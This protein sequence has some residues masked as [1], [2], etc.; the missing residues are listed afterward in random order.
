MG[1]IEGAVMQEVRAVRV[2]LAREGD[3]WVAQCLEY[4]I[5]AQA[6]DLDELRKRLIAALEAERQESLRRHGRSFAGIQPAPRIFHEQ[7]ERR[8][9]VRPLLKPATISDDPDIDIEFGFAA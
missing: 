8:T 6:R 2:L 1:A 7:W 5:G 4:D 3:Y 9:D